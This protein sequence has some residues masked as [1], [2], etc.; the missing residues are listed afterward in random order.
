MPKNNPTPVPFKA[1]EACCDP[2]SSTTLFVQS[3][4]F[5]ICSL[6]LFVH[7]L[8]GCVFCNTKF[9]HHCPIITFQ[10]CLFVY[11]Q[12]GH[13]ASKKLSDKSSE[14]ARSSKIWN[15]TLPVLHRFWPLSCNNSCW[16]WLAY[17]IRRPLQFHFNFDKVQQL[18]FATDSNAP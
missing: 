6:F 11:F 1:L 14:S 5:R 8:Y 3:W 9:V 18:P 15:R 12:P 7:Y 16:C 4:L 2:V 13:T 10:C 17:R